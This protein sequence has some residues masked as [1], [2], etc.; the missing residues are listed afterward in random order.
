MVSICVNSGTSASGFT[1]ELIASIPYIRIAKPTSIFPMSCFF[2]FLQSIIIITPIIARIGEN[3]IG[4]N[5]FIKKLSPCIPVR[6]N[7]HDVAVVPILAPI[8]IPTA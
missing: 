8:I 6:L 4:F 2:S 3:D 5:M 7:S 1:A